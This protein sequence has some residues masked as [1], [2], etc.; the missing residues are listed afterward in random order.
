MTEL[1]AVPKANEWGRLKALVLDSVSSPITLLMSIVLVGEGYLTV[2]QFLQPMIGNRHSVGITTEVIEDAVRAT[3]WRFGID[4][5]VG[6]VERR[7]IAG[8][9]LGI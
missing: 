3:E 7:Q 8:K 6:V 4:H 1:I 5:P 2:F 9:A